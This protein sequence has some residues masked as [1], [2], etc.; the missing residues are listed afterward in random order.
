MRK[1]SPINTQ[2]GRVFSLYGIFQY[3]VSDKRPDMKSVHPKYGTLQCAHLSH[4]ECL[5]EWTCIRTCCDDWFGS[6][7]TIHLIRDKTGSARMQ[8]QQQTKLIIGMT[9]IKI[10]VPDLGIF[11]LSL[12]TKGHSHVLTLNELKRRAKIGASR[13]KSTKFEPFLRTCGRAFS[14][15]A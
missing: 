12:D 7:A 13:Y 11:L 1:T 4:L 8:Q 3:S 14:I 6:F 5:G 9:L 10:L 15:D 2:Y